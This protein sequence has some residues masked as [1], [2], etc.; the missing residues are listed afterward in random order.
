MKQGLV[1]LFSIYFNPLLPIPPMEIQDFQLRIIY[2]SR[3]QPTVEAAINGHTAAAP[4]GASTGSHEAHCHVPDNLSDIRE[5]IVD[6][7]VGQELTQAEFDA[8]L[9]DIDNTD[10]FSNI[11]AAAIASSFAFMKA[12]GFDYGNRFPYP[13]GNLIGGGAHGGNTAIQEFL[14]LPSNASSIPEAMELLAEMYNLFK[15]KY[16][17]RIK[18]I[19]DEGAFVTNMD[20]EESLTTLKTVA[21]EYGASIGVDI[22]ATEFYEDGT[23]EYPEMNMSL[24][25]DQ[26]LK[27]VENLIDRFGLAY[28]EDPFEEEDF[29]RFAELRSRVQDTLIVGDDL[30]V[31]NLDR[32]AQGTAIDAGNA[33]IIKPNQIG[34]VTAAKQTLEQAVDNGYTPIVSH[35]SGE[36]CDPILADLAV[37]WDAPIIKAGIA[38]IRTA[39]NNQ[40]IRLWKG[41]GGEMAEIY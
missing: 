9:R 11:G 17:Q 16:K 34:T 5:Q 23:Y 8:A 29:E 18:G 13:L 31:T 14:L 20:D 12:A 26:Q 1:P 15:E 25:G 39:K 30:F 27:F 28:V 3:V 41:Y 19:N 40:L 22:A 36:T 4:S 38:G 7:V 32:L 37:A 6:D 10:N 24:P 21:D 2:N 33:I 35:R